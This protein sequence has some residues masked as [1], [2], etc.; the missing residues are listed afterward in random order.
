[1]GRKRNNILFQL[2]EVAVGNNGGGLHGELPFLFVKRTKHFNCKETGDR[3]RLR[4][5]IDFQ[6]SRISAVNCGLSPVSILYG[7]VGR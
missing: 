6:D 1:V 4:T 5:T 2:V 7:V 3:P